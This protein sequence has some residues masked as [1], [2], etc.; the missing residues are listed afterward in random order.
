LGGLNLIL[1]IVLWF[2][3]KKILF[4]TLSNLALLYF[5]LIWFRDINRE[6]IFQG[7]HRFVVERGF[8]IGIILFIF[9]EVI[10]FASFFWTFFHRSLTPSAEIGV[11]W[12]PFS[13]EGISP[14]EVPLLNTLILLRS[15]VRVT[16]S[17]FLI[18]QN[19][20]ASFSLFITLI[21]G[22]YFTLL[23]KI[24]YSEALFSFSD[25]VFGSIFFIATGFHGLHVII[26][27]ILLFYSLLRVLSHHFSSLNPIGFE[28][29]IWYW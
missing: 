10:F 21:L 26:G 12:P 22:V 6:S 23:Q 2:K 16:W 14:F 19:K 28:L 20:R 9:R 24:E 29:S 15:G 7:K 8:Q 17:H 1:S 18:L 11:V 27:S 5:I 4:L 13:I 25:S 3:F